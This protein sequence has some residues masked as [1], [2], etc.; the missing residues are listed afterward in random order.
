MGEES[1]SQNNVLDNSTMGNASDKEYLIRFDAMCG[2]FNSPFFNQTESWDTEDPDISSCF[3]KT[4]LMWIPCAFF[5]LWLPL[6]LKQLMHKRGRSGRPASGGTPILNLCKTV[7]AC[8][9]AI[10]AVI[11]LAF[12]IGGIGSSNQIAIVDIIDPSLRILTFG[13]VI[14]LLQGERLNGFITSWL[15]FFF[16]LLFLSFGAIS[17]YSNIRGYR[18]DSVPTR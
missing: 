6:R 16:W 14:A 4:I 13:A 3:R 7:I 8:I 5:W 2:P 15:Q 11:D 9:L 17:F 1:S 10:I 18:Q 12:A